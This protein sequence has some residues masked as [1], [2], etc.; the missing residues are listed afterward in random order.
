MGQ[1]EFESSPFAFVSFYLFLVVSSY[2]DMTT[3]LMSACK[4]WATGFCRG[5]I[6]DA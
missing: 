6:A 5:A 4:Q 1:R 3:E 2:L